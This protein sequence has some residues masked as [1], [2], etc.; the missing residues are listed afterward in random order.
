MEGA[1]PEADLGLRTLGLLRGRCLCPPTTPQKKGKGRGAPASLCRVD[2]FSGG[3]A[4]GGPTPLAWTTSSQTGLVASKRMQRRSILCSGIDF[5]SNF[6]SFNPVNTWEQVLI[7]R[8]IGG[9][10]PPSAGRAQA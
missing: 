9:S 10:H 4:A 1:Q 8:V 2:T 7:M 6:V 3:G 5:K